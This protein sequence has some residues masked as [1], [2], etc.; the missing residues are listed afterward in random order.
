[1]TK[2]GKL[3]GVLRNTVLALAPQVGPVAAGSTCEASA[4]RGVT[5]LGLAQDTAPPVYRVLVEGRCS[6]A[7][8]RCG[9]LPE[10]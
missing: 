8:F 9:L 5:V 10:S 4:P 7:F 6:A 2:A 3:A 1:M